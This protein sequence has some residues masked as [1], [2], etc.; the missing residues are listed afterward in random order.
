MNRPQ[1]SRSNQRRKSP[2]NRPAPVDMWQSPKPLPD[3][4]PIVATR[5]TGAMLRSLG[6]PHMTAGNT[7]GHYFNAVVERAAAVATALA[8]S[9]DLL[10]TPDPD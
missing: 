2:V 1:R 4:A 9:A 10:A 5:D 3:V 8:L 7:A 6:D